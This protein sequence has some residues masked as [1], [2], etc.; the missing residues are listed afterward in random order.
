MPCTCGRHRT[1]QGCRGARVLAA[2]PFEVKRRKPSGRPPASRRTGPFCACGCGRRC[3]HG[4]TWA[5]RRCYPRSLRVK[6]ARIGRQKST[7]T[8]RLRRYKTVLDRLARLPKITREDLAAVL[9]AEWLKGYKAHQDCV[10][11]G[12]REVA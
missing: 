3:F 9:Y 2:L 6:N 10:L 8:Q 7:V 1:E 12:G 4:C 11:R 5:S